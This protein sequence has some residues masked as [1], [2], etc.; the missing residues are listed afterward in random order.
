[1]KSCDKFDNVPVTVLAWI[2]V[3][4]I[5]LYNDKVFKKYGINKSQ[6][7]I[8]K[9]IDLDPEITQVKISKRLHVSKPSVTSMIQKMELDGL[10]ERAVDKDDQRKIKLE[11][12]KKGK[13]IIKSTNELFYE[14]ESKIFDGFS[15][16]EISNLK[17]SFQRIIKN[18]NK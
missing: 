15:K 4:N 6:S 10:I 16:E 14:I 18:I 7:A 13:E 9:M 8:L 1:M 12:T 3:H 11:V 17:Y 5:N 2:A